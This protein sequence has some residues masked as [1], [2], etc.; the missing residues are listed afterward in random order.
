MNHKRTSQMAAFSTIAL[1]SVAAAVAQPIG[2]NREAASGITQLLFPELGF[3]QLTAG[4][5]PFWDGS[6]FQDSSV[7]V[8]DTGE[9]AV[10]GRPQGKRLSVFAPDSGGGLFEAG[11]GWPSLEFRAASD[12]ADHRSLMTVHPQTGQFQ[13]RLGQGADGVNGSADTAVTVFPDGRV[14]FPGR[15]GVGTSDPINELDV[16]GGI[17]AD[18][19]SVR[20]DNAGVALDVRRRDEPGQ[21]AFIWRVGGG[22][23]GAYRLQL[24]RDD[25]PIN[26]IYIPARLGIAEPNPAATLDVAGTIKTHAIQFPDGSVQTSAIRTAGVELLCDYTSCDVLDVN[27]IRFPDGTVQQ[28]ANTG[29]SGGGSCNCL[30]VLIGTSNFN[31]RRPD[32]IGQIAVNTANRSIYISFCD[33]STACW[34]R[35]SN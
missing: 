15:V 32:G 30:P 4:Y 14:H 20:P 29:G 10:G 28:T 16:R 21:E 11:T 5:L 2:D 9:A 33:D 1:A 6:A 26:D 31:N 35:V 19:V 25:N 12:S 24:G 3:G 8:T 23:Y 18:G 7:L 27:A 34:E 13:L 17:R 22:G